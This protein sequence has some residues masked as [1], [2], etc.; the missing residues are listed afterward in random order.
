MVCVYICLVYIYMY[1]YVDFISN[2]TMFIIL[3][4]LLFPQLKKMPEVNC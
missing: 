4:A 1:G 3:K 2:H